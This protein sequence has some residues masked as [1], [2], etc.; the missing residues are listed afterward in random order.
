MSTNFPPMQGQDVHVTRDVV[1]EP[2]SRP[3]W[4]TG[5]GK[6]EAGLTQGSWASG[7]SLSRLGCTLA[8]ESLL[9]S[10]HWMPLD[11][12]GEAP[13][14]KVWFVSKPES[15]GPGGENTNPVHKMEVKHLFSRSQT[16]GRAK[17]RR[18]EPPLW[19]SWLTQTQ[20]CPSLEVLTP[21]AEKFCILPLGS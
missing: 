1:M 9:G 18:H 12:P 6:G 4:G 7:R 21:L 16:V 8:M 20:G 13:P 15:R 11:F 19:D 10:N 5:G 17:Q 14:L 3:S 2:V